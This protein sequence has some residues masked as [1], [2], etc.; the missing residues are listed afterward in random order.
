MQLK[1]KDMDIATG[2]PLITIL[3]R[4]DAHRYDLHNLDRIEIQKG[5]RKV[6]VILDIGESERAV[7]KGSIG[8]FE[9]VLSA[10]NAKAGDLVGVSV[11]K[12][13]ES[14]AFIR[15]KLDGK[16]LREEE[17]D[18]VVKGIVDGELSDVELTYFISGCY[19]NRL[20]DRET[21]ALTKSIV[22]YGDRI[23]VKDGPILD[24][25]CTGGVP[26]NR[27]TMIIVPILTSLGYFVPKTSSRS[28]TSPA[29]TADTMEV[30]APV[31]FPAEKI[32][33]ILKKVNGCIV[34]GGGLNLA[35]ADDKLIKIRNPLALDPEGMLLA[36]IL[37][38]KLAVGATHVLIDIPIGEETKIKTLAKA[39]RLEKKF[40]K[41]GR[42][43][44]MKI[45]VMITDGSEP[46]GNGIGPALEARD[47]LY[48]LKNDKR[49]PADLREK[50]IAMCVA[51]VEMV[52]TKNSRELIEQVLRSGTAYK[53]MKQ[54][55]KAQGGNPD[56][57]P[58]DIRL[59]KF[60]FNFRSAKSG[61]LLD[62]DNRIVSKVARIAGAPL[63]K[64]AGIYFYKHR[65]DA[66]KKGD[67]LYTVYSDNRQR[68]S[69]A[70]E[71]LGESQ[72]VHIG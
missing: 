65:N 38:K 26:N 55:I 58:S 19:I 69:Y 25:H 51:M 37:A 63:D 3:N 4:V 32:K 30:L 47:V 46:I 41:I 15:S 39:K 52:G 5:R 64:G 24:K 21:I 54:I 50:A 20:N 9:E 7:P 68:L 29:G 49:A 11:A 2:G 48:I 14:I 8:F 71:T 22:K 66:V 67:L 45:S 62:I 59:G 36:S 10:L 28:I 43:L 6:T 12:K 23:N 33:K 35:S 40:V 53:K 60:T 57:M 18:R 72:M 27:T 16:T 56:I 13:P 1:V 44:G 31:S 70:K 42:M 61:K 34:W 17:I